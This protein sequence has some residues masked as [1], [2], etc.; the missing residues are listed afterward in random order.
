M[1]NN[2]DKAQNIRAFERWNVIKLGFWAENTLSF[3]KIHKS[4]IKTDYKVYINGRYTT[5]I[6]HYGIFHITEK[7]R[8]R[9]VYKKQ[10][11]K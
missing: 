1:I 8:L 4:P 3:E 10:L 9:H 11:T 2:V 7:E 5:E 6:I